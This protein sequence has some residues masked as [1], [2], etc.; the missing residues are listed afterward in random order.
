MER[1]F[2]IAAQFHKFYL[3]DNGNLDIERI[4]IFKTRENLESITTKK[5]F[6]LCNG[7]FKINPIQ[8]YQMFITV[9][10][11][12][13]KA[14]STL[15]QWNNSRDEAEGLARTTKARRLA[16]GLITVFKPTTIV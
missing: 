13:K 14:Q 9:G 16:S 4:S 5:F 10:R 11:K 3:Y 6:L 7:N 1:H 12:P 15:Q 2:N 8:L